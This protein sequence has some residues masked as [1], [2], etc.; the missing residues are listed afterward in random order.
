[1]AG[2]YLSYGL[3]I[4]PDG[5]L[6]QVL[7]RSRLELIDLPIAREANIVCTALHVEAEHSVLEEPQP[8]FHLV[9]VLLCVN[10]KLLEDF[11]DPDSPSY[12]SNDARRRSQII[13]KRPSPG[14]Q[15]QYATQSAVLPEDLRCFAQQLVE[16]IVAPKSSIYETLGL[17]IAGYL[18]SIEVKG[19]CTCRACCLP[20]PAVLDSNVREGCNR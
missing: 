4:L 9:A 19:R 8:L 17:T 6:C 3:Y 2:Q 10:S 15:T 13:G 1:M 16:G 7:P 20:D 5:R 14:S 12:C 18:H 11:N